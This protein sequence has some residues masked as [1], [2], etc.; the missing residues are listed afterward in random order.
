LSTDD[1]CWA[2]R[3]TAARGRGTANGRSGARIVLVRGNGP[4]C[5]VED[6][7]N[8]RHSSGSVD[9]PCLCTTTPHTGIGH[10]CP[11]MDLPGTLVWLDQTRRSGLS[12]AAIRHAL[13]QGRVV[14]VRRGMYFVADFWQRGAAVPAVRTRHRRVPHRHRLGHGSAAAGPHRHGCR[15]YSR[16]AADLIRHRVRAAFRVVRTGS[17]PAG[18]V[19]PAQACHLGNSQ[20]GTG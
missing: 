13:A 4:A 1:V 20:A 17:A 7:P 15:A 11:A 5:H 8:R 10:A 14:R 3:G 9:G 12:E 18:D 6:E 2:V 19:G 16:P